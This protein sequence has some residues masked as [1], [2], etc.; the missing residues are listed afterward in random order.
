MYAACYFSIQN[1]PSWLCEYGFKTYAEADQYSRNFHT[2]ENIPGLHA[3]TLTHLN[4]FYP[5][6]VNRQLIKHDF[7]PE[8]KLVK[9]KY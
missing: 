1:G 4:P 7:A 9:T 5:E 2:S 8:V 3:T 6:F